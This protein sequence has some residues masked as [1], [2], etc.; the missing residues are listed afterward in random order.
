MNNI[1]NRSIIQDSQLLVLSLLIMPI[2]NNVKVTIA[3]KTNGVK[4]DLYMIAG[5]TPIRL[6]MKPITG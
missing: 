1:T 4:E 6:I 5:I 3:T 2:K